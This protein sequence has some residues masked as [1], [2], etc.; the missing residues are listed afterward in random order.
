MFRIK[1]NSKGVKDNGRDLQGLAR[2]LHQ[3]ISSLIAK[4]ARENARKKCL[5][6]MDIEHGDNLFTRNEK[7]DKHFAS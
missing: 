7:S 6:P 3:S 4:P 2:E 5:R 1:I